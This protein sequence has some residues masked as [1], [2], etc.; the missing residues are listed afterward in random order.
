MHLTALSHDRVTTCKIL[1]HGTGIA[2]RSHR[3]SPAQRGKI[4]SRFH[5]MVSRQDG[6]ECTRNR[7]DH[8]QQRNQPEHHRH[9]GAVLAPS[10]H[11][12]GSAAPTASACT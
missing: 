2:P 5:P 3:A 9:A 1:G 8:H 6:Y 11:D 10:R 4:S 7:A 12:P